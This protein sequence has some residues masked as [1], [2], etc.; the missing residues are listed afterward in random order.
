MGIPASG[1][2]LGAAVSGS[3]DLGTRESQFGAHLA[4]HRTY[5]SATMIAQARAQA[6][7]DLANGRLPW[8]S[9]KLP[10]SWADMAAGRGDAWALQVTQ[11]LSTVGGPVWIAFH[12]EP[13]GDGPIGDWVAMQRHLAPIVHANSNNIAFTI[14]TT[15]WDNWN[16]TDY[17]LANEWPGD[18]VVDILGTDVYNNYGTVKNGKTNTTDTDLGG[19]FAKVA[20]FAAAHHTRWAV[21]E[22]GY[23]DAAAQVDPTWLTRNFNELVTDGGI[24]M[25]YFDSSFNSIG[26]WT[27][28]TASKQDSF[29]TA[30]TT[31]S[32]RVCS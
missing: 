27:L 26:N 16:T 23:T 20:A 19:T 17:S 25:S 11:A 9:F 31:T 29:K 3:S 6:V 32:E 13:E 21:A 8:V 7:D 22:T 12:H 28:D 30:L 18:G 4:L 2:Y 5:F 24:G 1:A 15:G 10:Y 14:I